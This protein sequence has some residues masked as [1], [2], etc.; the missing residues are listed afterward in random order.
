MGVES[1]SGQIQIDGFKK[2]E[3]LFQE[4]IEQWKTTIPELIDYKGGL[5][6]LLDGRVY[7]YRSGRRLI[8]NGEQVMDTCEAPWAQATVDGLFFLESKEHPNKSRKLRVLERGAGLNISG[9]R[10]IQKMI[11]R[12]GGEYHVIELN[13]GIYEETLKWRERQL[14]YLN[15]MRRHTGLYIP[16]TIKVHFGEA[17]EVSR[18]L[19]E[20]ERLKFDIILSDTYPLEP[21]EEG[22]NDVIDIDIL[23]KGLRRKGLFGFFTYKPGETFLDNIFNAEMLVGKYFRTILSS[24]SY[25]NPP[26]D[27]TYLVD[28]EGVPIRKLPVLIGYDPK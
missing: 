22:I 23:R 28:K 18:R 21:Q 17:R 24:T 27:Y 5:V 10:I 15:D 16:L 13:E 8:I 4:T 7:R 9:T 1:K 12:G 2:T 6:H 11:E 20:D 26:L 14:D 25:V 3:H 19:M